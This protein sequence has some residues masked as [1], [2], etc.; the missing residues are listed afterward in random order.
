MTFWGISQKHVTDTW[1]RDTDAGMFGVSRLSAGAIYAN[2]PGKCSPRRL[3]YKQDGWVV[4]MGSSEQAM[5]RG[6]LYKGITE[7]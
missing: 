6:H 5:T 3:G 1:Q 7:K 2:W 4:I